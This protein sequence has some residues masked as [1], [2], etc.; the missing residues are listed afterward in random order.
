[1]PPHVPSQTGSWWGR[2]LREGKAPPLGEGVLEVDGRALREP[3]A[4]TLRERIKEDV[5]QEVMDFI[6]SDLAGEVTGEPS[7]EPFTPD[8]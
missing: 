8:E 7:T 4:D 3:D 1:V 5:V 2:W 6:F